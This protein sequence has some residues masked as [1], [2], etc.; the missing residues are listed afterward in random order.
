MKDHPTAADW[1][2]LRAW[3]ASHGPA[4]RAVLEYMDEK[5]RAAPVLNYAFDRPIVYGVQL[6][7]VFVA[8]SVLEDLSDRLDTKM[9]TDEDCLQLDHKTAEVLERHGLA[10]K[11]SRG[12]WWP[13]EVLRP[14]WEDYVSG[15][16]AA[17]DKFEAN[18]HAVAAFNRGALS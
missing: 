11:R 7:S 3:L 13:T 17:I 4:D 5:V 14:F 16:Q 9:Y 15:R 1:Y 10:E 8:E 18:M 6:G 12:G 2:T